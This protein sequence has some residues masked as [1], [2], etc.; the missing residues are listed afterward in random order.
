MTRAF[1]SQSTLCM[2]HAVAPPGAGQASPHGAGLQSSRCCCCRPSL[3]AHELH[4]PRPH[5]PPSP[6]RPTGPSLPALPHA[7]AACSSTTP[8]AP[9]TR[10]HDVRCATSG[11]RCC[12]CSTPRWSL[13]TA[14]G[15]R[16]AATTCCAAAWRGIPAG[17]VWGWVWTAAVPWELCTGA[18]A[19]AAA[20]GSTKPVCGVPA[21]GAAAAAAAATAGVGAAASAS[22]VGDVGLAGGLRV[23]WVVG[24]DEQRVCGG[25]ACCAVRAVLS[26]G[27]SLS[28]L[29]WQMTACQSY[30]EGCC[31]GEHSIPTSSQRWSYCNRNRNVLLWISKHDRAL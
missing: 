30:F 4:E 23:R 17:T 2:L 12:W 9:G 15:V 6:P 19:T 21:A 1:E 22:V 3:S 24:C 7:D 11:P 10:I 31:P 25:V 16:A 18:P 20:A 28:T 27:S 13:P 5:F 29:C 8:R 14:W 26:R